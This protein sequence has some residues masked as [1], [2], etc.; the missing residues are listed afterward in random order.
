MRKVE[1]VNSKGYKVKAQIMLPKY[2]K[3][4]DK[5]VIACHGFGSNKESS[6]IT[7]L[8]NKLREHNIA[9]LSFDFTGHGESD[10]S[11]EQI[12]ITNCIE[13]VRAVVN[14]VRENYKN[15]KIGI[16]ASSFGAAV[17][18]SY[19][20]TA[21]EKVDA[22]VLRCPTIEMGYV[23][24]DVLVKEE[25]E[26]IKA[27]GYTYLGFDAA[28]KIPYSFYEDVVRYNLYKLFRNNPVKMLIIHGSDDDVVP[29]E[30]VKRFANIHPE[31]TKLEIFEG[32]DHRFKK[33]K[34]VDRLVEMGLRYYNQLLG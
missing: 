17:A 34:E 25:I 32:T 13:D 16:F 12:N 23:F 2:E 21:N 9:V 19:L 31:L 3:N 1:I 7:A 27:R 10:V 18:L 22:L 26:D 20:F 29:L 30:H 15:S 6:T 4:T 5:I 24:K 11:T 8:T 33:E 28:M 14:Y